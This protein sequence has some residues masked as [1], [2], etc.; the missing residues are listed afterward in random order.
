MIKA[1]E[2][3]LQRG[4]NLLNSIS[5]SDYSEQSIPPYFSSIGCHIRH[6]LDMFTC[7]LN[8]VERGNIDLTNR[9]RNQEAEQKCYAGIDYFQMII[10]RMS[11]L[12]E[13]DL[14]SE[15]LITDDLGA[16]KITS[17]TTI[18]A[19]LMQVQSHTIHHYAS[20]GYIIHQLGIEL[21]DSDF[22]FNP[23]TPNKNLRAS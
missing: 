19:A 12:S 21:P 23:T 13:N 2:I 17:K 1:I 18:G 6:V 22:G 4:I 3:N 10:K 20:I 16:G 14:K 11:L 7:V 15:I 9:E 5:D 8:G